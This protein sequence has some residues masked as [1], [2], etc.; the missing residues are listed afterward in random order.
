MN[1]SGIDLGLAATFPTDYELST[2]TRCA[3]NEA[4]QLA[5]TLGMVNEVVDQG[6]AWTTEADP[7]LDSESDVESTQ[8]SSTRDNIQDLV[9]QAHVEDADQALPHL[10]NHIVVH[11]DNLVYA[12]AAVF[13]EQAV[14]M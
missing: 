14:M 10:A 8:E 13:A 7:E 1:A 2:L 11:R 3:Y 5:R 12:T 9:E 4:Q 6:P